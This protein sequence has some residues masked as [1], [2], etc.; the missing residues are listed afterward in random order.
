MPSYDGRTAFNAEME[1][2]L[3]DE[4]NLVAGQLIRGQSL[5]GD[6]THACDRIQSCASFS[7]RTPETI[8]GHGIQGEAM[9]GVTCQCLPLKTPPTP[10][11][12]WF[13]HIFLCVSIDSQF[14]SSGGGK[15]CE[16]LHPQNPILLRIWGWK[17]SVRVK[18]QVQMM[19][20]L[21][22]NYKIFLFTTISLD[23]LYFWRLLFY[24]H[25]IRLVNEMQK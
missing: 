16:I 19:V 4:A 9:T 10:C 7:Q 23:G 11:L 12:W 5:A 1:S 13:R 6:D 25:I 15:N 17:L 20:S 24:L 2:N 22:L 21:R 18:F 8:S 14:N 3:K